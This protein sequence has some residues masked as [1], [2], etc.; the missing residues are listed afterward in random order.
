[1]QE[2]HFAVKPCKQ[3]YIRAQARL[4]ATG[5]SHG[6]R[7]I[8]GSFKLTDGEWFHGGGEPNTTR[9]PTHSRYACSSM[10]TQPMVLADWVF[11]YGSLIWNPEFNSTEAMLGKVHGLHRAFCLR[12]TRF[13]GTPERPGVVLGLDH[14]GSCIGLAYRLPMDERHAILS[15]IYEREMTGGIYRDRCVNVRLINGRTIQALTFVANHRHEAY[16]RLDEPTLIERL[17]DCSGQR[18]HNRDYLVNTER[19]L[20]T[21]GV[22]DRM[23]QR[24]VNEVV[25]RPCP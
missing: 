3:R 16:E 9:G 10:T 4:E 1:M 12:S 13:R 17:R 20:R 18:G 6:T 8:D 15:K 14:G 25:S 23:L 7:A 22:R 24:L 19:S 21:H 5:R 2:D 11:A